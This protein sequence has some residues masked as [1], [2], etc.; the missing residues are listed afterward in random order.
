MT[1]ETRW[2]TATQEK[3]TA[4]FSPLSLSGNNNMRNSSTF[5]CQVP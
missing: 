2:P 5:G 4:K 1:P 3:T